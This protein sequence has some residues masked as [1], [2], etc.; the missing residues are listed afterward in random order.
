MPVE[1]SEL[2]D[3]GQVIRSLPLHV[4]GLEKG[5]EGAEGVS[6]RVFHWF[7][8][9]FVSHQCN[10]LNGLRSKAL[11]ARQRFRSDFDGTDDGGQNVWARAFQCLFLAPTDDRDG[12]LFAASTRELSSR[13]HLHIELLHTEFKPLISVSKISLD[14]L[15]RLHCS[16]FL[17]GSGKS[18]SARSRCHQY[19][20]L[21]GAGLGNRRFRHV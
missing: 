3:S 7:L 2:E 20:G 14:S 9:A 19:L 21:V 11:R 16:G 1:C 10:S 12:G 13:A 8:S 5:I 4:R 18:R 15:C 6:N 17:P